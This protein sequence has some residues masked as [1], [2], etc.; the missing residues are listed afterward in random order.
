M[1]NNTRFKLF[2]CFFTA[3]CAT[4]VSFSQ[5]SLINN[6]VTADNNKQEPPQ[7]NKDYKLNWETKPFDFQLFIENKGE[8]DGA[9]KSKDEIYYSA[10]LGKANAYFTKKGV[11]YSYL[12]LPQP[13]DKREREEHER[14]KGKEED[15]EHETQYANLIW[16]G[17][18]ADVTIV[19]EGV[20]KYYYTYPLGRDKTIRVNV[21]RKIIYKN[22]YDNIDV[23]YIFPE[24]KEGIKYNVIVRSGGDISKVKLKYKDAEGMTINADGDIIVKTEMGEFTDHAPVCNNDKGNKMQIGYSI[25]NN[26]ESFLIKGNY[27]KDNTIIIDPWTTNPVFTGGYNSAYEVDYDNQGNVY[28][29]G[30]WGPAQLVKFN[31]AGVIQWRF[32]ATTINT[33]PSAQWG[34]LA[35]DHTTGTSYMVDGYNSAPVG[36][37]CIKVNNAGMLV[38]TFPG[39]TNFEEMDRMSFSNCT[40]QLVIAGGG[41]SATNQGCIVDTTMAA[42]GFVPKN[43]LNANLPYHDMWLLAIDPTGTTCYMGSTNSCCNNNVNYDDRLLKLNIPALT[44][45]T[46]NFNNSANT[47]MP[48]ACSDLIYMTW[49]AVPANGFNGM[50]A[51]KTALYLFDGAD[52]FKYNKNSG[53]LQIHRPNVASTMQSWGGLDVDVCDVL[54]VGHNHLIGVYNGATL[55]AGSNPT[56]TIAVSNTIYDL[57]LGKN[58]QML[59]ASGQGF[60]SSFTIAVPSVTLTKIK[61]QP[62]C[63]ACNG[64][65]KAYVTE[66]G[67]VDSVG[68]TYLWSNG[69]TT[70]TATGLCAG[71]YTVS[72]TPAGTC[73]PYVDTVLLT[74]AG[75]VVTT[76][77]TSLT[78]T[79]T[80]ATVSAS[81]VTTGV[82]YSWAGTGIVSGGNT[83]TATVNAV[84]S[85]TV[86]V[87]ATGCSS[88]AIANVVNTGALPNVTAGAP[89][90]L[91]C[92]TTSGNITAS[93]TTAGVTYSW[94]GSGITAGGTTSA[95]TVN[96]VGTYTV[97]VTN[98]ANGCTNTATVSVT[99]SG[100]LPNVTAGAPLV[101]N[102]TTTSGN[103]SASS[104]TAGVTYSWAGPG[105]TSGGNTSAATVNAVGVYTVTVTNPANGCTNTATVNVTN[106]G[107]LPN[108]TA[109]AP[110]ALNCITTS[111]NISA[112]STTAGVTYSWSGAGITAGG[113]TSTATVNTAGTYTVTVTDPSNGCTNS[114]TVNV[115]NSGT[116]P[117]VTAGAPLVLNCATASGNISA[118][119]TTAGVTYSWVGA[120]ITSGGT[121]STATVNA[122]GTYTV[123]VTD[124]SNG[125]TNTATVSVTNSGTQPNVTGGPPLALN[126]TTTSGNITANST[127]AGA[128][129]NWT[130]PNVTAGGTTSTATVNT[131]G[132]YTVTV[133]DPSTSCTNTA[134]VVVTNTG[135]VPNVTAGAALALN[136]T[137][138]S[139]TISASATTAGVTYSWAGGSITAGGSTSTATVNA[140]GTYT[141]TVTDPNTGCLNSTTVNVTN[142]NNPP[143][144]TS[145]VPL[146][147]TCTSTS[148]TI[149]ASS[150]TAG[151]TYNWAGAGITA[152]GATSAAT[153]NAIGTYTVTVTDPGNGC[154]STAS[155]NVSS[156]NSIP[157][158]TGGAALSLNCTITSGTISASSTTAGVTYSWAGSGIISGGTTTTPLVNAAGTYT[159]TVTDPVSLCTNTATVIVTNNN[160]PPNV[161]P[162]APASIS[163][164]NQTGNISAT[165]TTVG[166]TYHWTGAGIVSGG[167]TSSPTVSAA[168]TYTI[169]VTDPSNGCTNSATVLVSASGGPTAVAGPNSV[170]ILGGSATI[171][172]GG[173]GSYLWSNGATSDSII[174]SPTLTTLYCV[175]VKDTNNCT[176]TACAKVLV[177]IP[178]PTDKDLQV[179]NAFSPNGDGY[180]DEF[181]LQGWNY[182]ISEFTIFIFDRWGEKVFQSTDPEFCWD[183]TYKGKQLDP[184]VFVYFITATLENKN[185]VAKKGNI[186]LIR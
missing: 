1:N 18:N 176:D 12:D 166:V 39:N 62:T 14:N 99:N 31:S 35:V 136:C 44:A 162:G 175:T 73:T 60:V 11:T 65:A 121:T 119:S 71:T 72:I 37:R 144:V 76:S 186:S 8:F 79:Q 126:C 32:N 108:V 54:Y 110:L 128:T 16:E 77:S 148:G 135:A 183:G 83:S 163:C 147:L 157:A 131:A 61:V 3:F 56:S 51:S 185:T 104:T 184:A 100:A 172:A 141:V 130:G 112:S 115:T 106:S 17:A 4:G 13:K 170:I 143:N 120:G 169:T 26:T 167:T 146:I 68:A 55:A 150:T 85:Y 2:I 47:F 41:T 46:F 145:G 164:N 7:S 160:T 113:T 180:N 153:V 87:S 88:T 19:A 105:I 27:N 109:G 10:K 45:S 181:C 75:P 114:A 178:C 49:S 9:I 155:V 98:P 132:T 158:V 42:G 40:H 111:G 124:P 134:T 102:C 90:V 127:T 142:N 139:G 117:N 15:E 67:V 21:Y 116:L 92:V 78:C 154:V 20:E 137:V 57:K 122:I 58:Y 34:D 25:K 23:E 63:G 91:N 69:S 50:V 80:T 94:A 95:A 156:N 118:S 66:C 89:L 101:L 22:L 64:S 93:S 86:T 52:L 133:T 123:T 81:T 29:Y 82:T 179:P 24:S 107:A 161:T 33:D 174:V 48:E 38:G 152:G 159:V 149:S 151:V 43:V 138:I 74:S 171:F 165:S 173:G 96:A 182:C 129:Y 177:E 140:A 70:S 28:T 97:T 59:Y 30:A 6:S 36:A 103:V 5:T 53:A 84:G 125:C 168:G